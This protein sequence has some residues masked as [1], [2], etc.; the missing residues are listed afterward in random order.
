MDIGKIKLLINTVKYL[1]PLQVYYR[2]YYFVKNRTRFFKV[3]QKPVPAIELIMWEQKL[4]S[5]ISY[6]KRDKSF[7]FLNIRHQFSAQID[8]NC[9]NYGKLWTYNLNYFDF[10]NQEGMTMETGVVLINDYVR[11]DMTLKDGKE[12]YTISLRNINWIKFLSKN[13]INILTQ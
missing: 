8:W 4:N 7:N 2:L 6:F 1:K 13:Q 12:P 9:N 10:L 5:P 11:N 3:I